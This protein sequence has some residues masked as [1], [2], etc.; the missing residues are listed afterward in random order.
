MEKTLKKLRDDVLNVK[1]IFNHEDFASLGAE[2]LLV[3]YQTVRS[4]ADHETDFQIR[5]VG[6]EDYR[7]Y[8]RSRYNERHEGLRT[9]QHRQKLLADLLRSIEEPL[10]TEEQVRSSLPDWELCERKRED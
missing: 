6:D 4:E 1:I 3:L 5:N 2:E 9:L 7:R 8:D 10:P